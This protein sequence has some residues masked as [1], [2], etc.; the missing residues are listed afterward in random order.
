MDGGV[1]FWS[2]LL[3]NNLDP[4]TTQEFSKIPS[5]TKIYKERILQKNSII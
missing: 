4:K 5:L 1:D 3:Q 2:N